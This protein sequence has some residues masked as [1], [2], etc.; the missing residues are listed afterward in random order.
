MRQ[1]IAWL[2]AAEQTLRTNSMD[3]L[4][5]FDGEAL[6]DQIKALRYDYSRQLGFDPFDNAALRGA[7]LSTGGT[8]RGRQPRRRHHRFPYRPPITT[9]PMQTIATVAKDVLGATII[10]KEEEILVYAEPF[11][12]TQLDDLAV[13]QEDKALAIAFGREAAG[14]LQKWPRQGDLSAMPY[15]GSFHNFQQ[16]WKKAESDGSIAGV[17]LRAVVRGSSL[18]MLG[19]DAPASVPFPRA[20][21]MHSPASKRA[22]R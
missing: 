22:S 5:Q 2:P 17:A 11:G 13:R 15:D 16:L 9:K 12:N 7:W 19:L 4:A 1:L 20:S 18:Q 10:R 8:F 3:F 6:G 14:R 21:Q